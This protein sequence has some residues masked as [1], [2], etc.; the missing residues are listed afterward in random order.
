MLLGS[1]LFISGCRLSITAKSNG[2]YLHTD[3]TTDQK[4][5]LFFY[6]TFRVVLGK[7]QHF[8]YDFPGSF[9]TCIFLGK[10]N[11]GQM[12]AV[13][14]YRI[15]K[16]TINNEFLCHFFSLLS[17]FFIMSM[18]FCLHTACSRCGVFFM[19][20]PIRFS[21]IKINDRNQ[22]QKNYV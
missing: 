11:C 8:C 20:F 12:F 4:I 18:P 21:V 9:F 10:K 17:A 19:C 14:Q 5:L 7:I 16:Y 15:T 13:G 22:F 3:S 1:M 2:V 6:Y